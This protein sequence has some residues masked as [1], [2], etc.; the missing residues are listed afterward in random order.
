MYEADRLVSESAMYNPLGLYS[1]GKKLWSSPI[2]AQSGIAELLNTMGLISQWMLYGEEFDPTY[3]TGLYAGENKLTIK[4]KRNIP[5]YHS[6]Y[7]L[8]RLERN[9]RYYKLGDNML[10]IIPVK[11]IAEHINEAID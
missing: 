6:I 5:I 9:N 2:A 11:D 3:Q 8:D 7:M 4:L 10:S 1:E